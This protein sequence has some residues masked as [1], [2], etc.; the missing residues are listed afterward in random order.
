MES[1]AKQEPELVSLHEIDS[2]KEDVLAQLI[3]EWLRCACTSARMQLMMKQL[4]EEELEAAMHGQRDSLARAADQRLN[5]QKNYY[6]NELSIASRSEDKL[7]KR[8][9]ELQG[10]LRHMEQEKKEEEKRKDA[11][12]DRERKYSPSQTNIGLPPTPDSSNPTSE[13]VPK[14]E[15]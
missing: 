4:R 5:E 15:S 6:E 10:R 11:I 7:R 2:E 3:I 13:D 9:S 12:T 14:K 1:L 8:I